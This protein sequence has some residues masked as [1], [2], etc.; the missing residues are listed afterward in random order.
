MKTACFAK[1]IRLVLHENHNKSLITKKILHVS[2][3]SNEV[4]LPQIHHTQQH[5]FMRPTRL[6]ISD[7][8]SKTAPS[9]HQH[10]QLARLLHFMRE[11]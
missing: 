3:L 1:C 4:G 9:F 8:I 5:T 10:P 2:G 6:L 11:L 7:S